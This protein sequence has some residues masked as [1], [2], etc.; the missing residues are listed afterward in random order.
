MS[1]LSGPN[2]VQHYS[3]LRVYSAF[4][5]VH[6]LNDVQH[7]ELSLPTQYCDEYVTEPEHNNQSTYQRDST[8]T[9]DQLL[10]K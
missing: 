9:E 8:S 7:A 5:C 1:K 6:V 2:C 4:V 10:H 3:V